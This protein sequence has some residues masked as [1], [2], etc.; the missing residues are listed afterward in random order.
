MPQLD[1][2]QLA[3]RAAALRPGLPVLLYTGNADGIDD[4]EAKRH[5]VCGVLRKPVDADALHALMQR[6]LKAG[7]IGA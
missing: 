1:G 2:L 5:G 4:A 7:R 3:Q 6:C